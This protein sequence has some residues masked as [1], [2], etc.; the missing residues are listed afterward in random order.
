MYPVAAPTF[1]S[2]PP[3][4]RLRIYGHVLESTPRY[5][6]RNSSLGR[7]A[8][9]GDYI[10][11]CPDRCE[12]R[13]IRPVLDYDDESLPSDYDEKVICPPILLVGR[14][15]YTEA[16]SLFYGR[17]NFRFNL[18]LSLNN[19]AFSLKRPNLCH[20]QGV[21]LEINRLTGAQGEELSGLAAGLIKEAN[22]R[23]QRKGTLAI[24]FTNFRRLQDYE[25]ELLETIKAVTQFEQ[26]FLVFSYFNYKLLLD[27]DKQS[28]PFWQLK[29][30]LEDAFGVAMEEG[31]TRDW[32]PFPVFAFT[33]GSGQKANHN[34]RR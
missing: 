25:G 26:I 14:Q 22:A 7:K 23:A 10:Y 27:F 5:G 20:M 16:T 8:F 30:I 21:D 13:Y 12:N 3:E 19:D 15:T 34:C 17:N 33:F 2:L 28:G 18:C 9:Y 29:A 6:F 24:E 32:P 31:R 4:I 11:T 1:D